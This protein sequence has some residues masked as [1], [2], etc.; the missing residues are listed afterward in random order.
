MGATRRSCR[1]SPIPRFGAARTV[2]Q[3]PHK[4]DVGSIRREMRKHDGVWGGCGGVLGRC[5]AAEADLCACSRGSS[6]LCSEFEAKVL[7][8]F[9]Y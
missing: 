7:H 6:W 9:E 5:V 8:L 1:V 2:L 3:E 4:R